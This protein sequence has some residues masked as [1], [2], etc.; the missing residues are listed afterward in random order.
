LRNDPS[1]VERS[2]VGIL[3]F[4]RRRK[5]SAAV[6]DNPDRHHVDSL[7]YFEEREGNIHCPECAKAQKHVRLVKTEGEEM[8]CPECHYLHETRRV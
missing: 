5:K 8:E 1:L 3:D 4:F 7:D 2:Y 6:D